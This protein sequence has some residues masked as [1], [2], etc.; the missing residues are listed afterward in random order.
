MAKSAPDGSTLVLTDLGSVTISPAVMKLVFDVVKDF[1]GVTVLAYS[2]HL[3]AVA[4]D[5][6]YKT[7]AELIAY[8][9]ANPG[10][11]TYA[12]TGLGS[13]N[14]LG[15]EFLAAEAGGL[16]LTHVP[17][18]GGAPAIELK[19]AG[20]GRYRVLVNGEPLKHA[21]GD[22][23][24]EPALFES[25]AA[26]EQAARTLLRKAPMLSAPASR[27]TRRAKRPK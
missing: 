23:A 22:Q 11:V 21:E 15:A 13:T 1:S 24:G 25:K 9:K 17:Y 7:V 5:R 12:S 3:L 20:G 4:P 27:L 16:K 18:R 26:A 19:H 6:P 10:K 2:P 8:A 14:Q